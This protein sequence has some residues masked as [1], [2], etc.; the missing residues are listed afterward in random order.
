VGISQRDTR[1]SY[2]SD[3]QEKSLKFL[4]LM[5]KSGADINARV[6]DTSSH[7]AIIARPSSMTNRQGQ[8]A[9]FGAINWGWTKVAQFLIDNGAKLDVK[10]DAGKSV[11]DALKGGAGGRD[12]KASEEMGK[13]IRAAAGVS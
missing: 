7:S 8:T 10:D 3:A 4:E 2:G 11:I 1:G 9:I 5:L 6:A 13:L 12:L